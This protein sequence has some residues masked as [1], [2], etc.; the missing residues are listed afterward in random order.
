MGKHFTISIDSSVTTFSKIE[1]GKEVIFSIKTE[2]TILEEI[3]INDKIIAS[4]ED[5][6]YYDFIVIDIVGDSIKLKKIF[7]ISKSIGLSLE[8]IGVFE[9]IDIDEY[10]SICSQ[11]FSDFFFERSTPTTNIIENGSIKEEF[12]SWLF[13]IR[14]YYRV[15]KDDRA[16]L[17]EKLN[18]YEIAYNNDFG[19]KIFDYPNVS[20]EMIINALETNVI[21]DT[22]DIGELNRKTVG[23]GAVKAILGSKNYIKFL[24]D[25]LNNTKKSIATSNKV[26]PINKIYFGAPGTGKS[27]QITQDLKEVDKIFQKR[28][29]FHP[30]YDNASFVGSYKPIT[31]NEG[32]IKYEFCPQIFTNIF[33]ES[34]NDPNHQYYLI[35]EEINRGNCAEIFG[36]LFQLLDR[37]I[38]YEI[39]PSN[40]LINY[41]NDNIANSK[42]YIDGKMLLPDN[43]SILATMNTSDQSLFPMDSAFKRRWEWEYI[44]I[45]YN[46]DSNVNKSALYHIR[47]DKSTSVKWI[48]FIENINFKIKD[49]PNLGLDKCIGNYFVK[50]DETNEISI[51]TFIYKVIFYLWN[52]VFK[53][54]P[55]NS[56]FKG[57]ITYQD[58]F[59]INTIGVANV[60]LILSELNIIL[61]TEPPAETS[62]VA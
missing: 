39:S 11:L 47:L 46:I 30:E 32:E 48:D 60:K 29:T 10:E 14:K 51:E 34:C 45:N 56:I 17:I 61:S 12:A 37:D 43:L 7:E 27:Y 40:E 54:E 33:I 20:I 57:K 49:N 52:D 16:I 6:V 59:P 50:P 22:G 55:V 35:I 41:L 23:N 21:N 18:E 1:S 4:I 36:E 42:F 5:E 19:I 53:D 24:K 2:Q 9:Q 26:N 38:N 44:P 28:V 13:K 58:F 25:L 3:A 31:N 8:T 15:Y 62:T